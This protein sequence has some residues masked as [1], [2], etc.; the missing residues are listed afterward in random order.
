M[1]ADDSCTLQAFGF[2]QGDEFC[3]AI[4]DRRIRGCSKSLT[5]DLPNRG[6]MPVDPTSAKFPI[7]RTLR[8]EVGGRL[9]ALDDCASNDIGDVDEAML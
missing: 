5:L 7:Q 2:E 8:Y 6:D 3:A 9:L 1:F 4:L